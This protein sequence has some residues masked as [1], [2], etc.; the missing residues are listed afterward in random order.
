MIKRIT[1]KPESPP[2]ELILAEIRLTN[3]I[4]TERI[5]LSF[6]IAILL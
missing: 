1:I 5:P 4:K 3:F 6:C 2:R